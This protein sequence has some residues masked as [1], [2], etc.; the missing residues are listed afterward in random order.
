M[1]YVDS[2]T[3]VF[4]SMTYHQ[5]GYELRAM[6]LPFIWRPNLEMVV[7]LSSDIF[8]HSR[9]LSLKNSPTLVGTG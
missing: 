1:R 4:P 3:L 2:L 7:F 6:Q 8:Y 9:T 5:P